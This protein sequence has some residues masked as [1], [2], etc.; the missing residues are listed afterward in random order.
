MWFNNILKF[1]GSQISK[2]ITDIYNKSLTCGICTNCLKC[3]IIKPC[4]KKGDKTQLSN[5]RPISVF[6]SFSKIFELLIFH[7]SKHNLVSINILA[8][9][10]FSFH[11]NV[12]TESAIFKLESIF[13]EWNNKEYITGL[14]YDLTKAF[15]SVNY[16]LLILKLEF[17]GV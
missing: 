1:Y 10:Q 17:Y 12:S 2:P 8:N 16:E 15:D 13:S 9:E 3:A 5:Y 7:R 6:T 4:F 11:D 14:F